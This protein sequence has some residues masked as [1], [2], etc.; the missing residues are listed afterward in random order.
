MATQLEVYNRALQL[1]DER[2]LTSVSE[3]RP[4]RHWMDDSWTGSIE[5]TEE[6][7]DWRWCRTSLKSEADPAIDPDWGFRKV[8]TKPA[9]MAR[10]SLMCTDEHF[11]IPL[12][13]YNEDTEVW[14]CD[15]DEIY[16]GYVP[17]DTETLLASWPRYYVDYVAAELAE[18]IM[19][20]VRNSSDYAIYDVKFQRLKRNAKS[21]D[22]MSG[23]PGEIPPGDWV[24]AVTLGSNRRGPKGYNYI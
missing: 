18:R 12:R 23:P 4:P 15:H 19:G 16:I 3:D 11:R 10:L 21:L 2:R 13:R 1:L 6:D 8:H 7:Y 22:S 20:R 9:D 17:N 14:Y 24:S 5:A